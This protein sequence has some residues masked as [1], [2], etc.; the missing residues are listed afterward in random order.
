M[1]AERHQSMFIVCSFPLN[2]PHTQVY[3]S[4]KSQVVSCASHVLTA[5]GVV[6]GKPWEPVNLTPTKSTYLNRSRKNLSQV[7][8]FTTSTAV[9][10]LVV[11]PAWGASGQIGEILTIFRFLF[12][13]TPLSNSPTGQ[14]AHHIFMLNGSNGVYSRQGVP[15]WLWLILQP[16]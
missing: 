14:T 16:I 2:R 4:C 5:T 7:I 13:P 10:N 6:N 11:I 3:R 9:Q 1:P 15:F 8:R 12:L